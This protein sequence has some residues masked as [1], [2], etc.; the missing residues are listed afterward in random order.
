[1][2]H[3][4]FRGKRDEAFVSRFGIDLTDELYDLCCRVVLRSYSDGSPS[5]SLGV[6]VYSS[7]LV[8]WCSGSYADLASALPAEL[9]RQR[10]QQYV[11]LSIVF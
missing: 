5:L 3:D 7:N 6:W 2:A 9:S 4:S 10:G 11:L 8:T 1:V